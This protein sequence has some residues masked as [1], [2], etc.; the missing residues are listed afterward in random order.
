MKVWTWLYSKL[1]R[2]FWYISVWTD[3]A[4]PS[5]LTWPPAGRRAS[6]NKQQQLFTR[7]KLNSS[8][9][10][11]SGCKNCTVHLYGYEQCWERVS[12]IPLCLAVT[13]MLWFIF[14]F[15]IKQF[16]QLFTHV[17]LF[18]EK[19]TLADKKTD[20]PTVAAS[21]LTRMSF[22]CWKDGDRLREKPDK[23]VE[24]LPT[25]HKDHWTVCYIFEVGL[26]LHKSDVTAHPFKSWVFFFFFNSLEITHYRITLSLLFQGDW[27]T[28]LHDLLGKQM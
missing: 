18:C 16:K 27:C 21:D 23:C 9:H 7:R 25:G 8:F 14:L 4:L 15:L 20:G 24:A 2:C 11:V 3:S 12:V 1:S 26:W 28:T 10:R 13:S 5:E 17:A 6:E 19:W 22:L